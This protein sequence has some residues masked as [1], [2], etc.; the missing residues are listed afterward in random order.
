MKAPEGGV[1]VPVAY[2]DRYM[3]AGFNSITDG[4]NGLPS[5]DTK[6]YV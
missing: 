2:E 1:D 4:T 5:F 3:Y 6:I